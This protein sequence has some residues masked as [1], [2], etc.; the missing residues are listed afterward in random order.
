MLV[1][2]E[3]VPVLVQTIVLVPTLVFIHASTI[4]VVMVPVTYT[5]PTIVPTLFVSLD[6]LGK[7]FLLL[8][9]ALNF[10]TTFDIGSSFLSCFIDSD[11]M[12]K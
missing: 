11:S 9:D 2:F 4:L 12:M 7:A 10:P 8:D 1:T 3:L 6:F 5:S